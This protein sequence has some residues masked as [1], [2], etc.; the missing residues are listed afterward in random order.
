MFHMKHCVSSSAR[1]S[2]NLSSGIAALLEL[3]ACR[4]DV[5][6]TRIADR[7]LNTVH[8]EATLQ[9]LDL[10][11]GRRS[12]RTV[13]DVIQLNKVDV[14]HSAGAEVDQCLHLGIVVVDAVDHGIFIGGTATGLLDIGLDC[15]MK[16]RECVLFNAGHELV[17]RGLDGR[18]QG[19]SERKLFGKLGETLDARDNAAGRD[20]EMAGTDIE[21]LGVVEHAESGDGLVEI[22]ERFTLA[23]EHHAGNTLAK[24]ASNMENLIYH[25]LRGERAGEAGQAGCTESA[26]H[27]APGLGGDADGELVPIG[28][29]DGLDRDPIGKLEQILAGAVLG[30]LLDKLGGDAE[31]E[32]LVQ[33]LAQ[34]CG[35]VCHLIERT[36]VLLMKP[37]IEL[38]SAKRRLAQLG[39][40]LLELIEREL[41]DIT[42]TVCAVHI[43][44]FTGEDTRIPIQ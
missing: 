41:A 39:H 30:D 17:A 22:H 5:T 36:N 16:T 15:L 12:E 27:G 6:A 42:V 3:T 14:A 1:G 26:S 8:G 10:L 34:G 29:A 37:L 38:F 11:D 33:L 20:G 24:I 18:V 40:E 2:A 7:G 13:S 43:L 35:K 9:G 4:I 25:F 21:P 19:N 28:H 32:G 44:P 31:G 23:H